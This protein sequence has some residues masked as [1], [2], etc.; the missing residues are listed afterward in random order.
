MKIYLDDVRQTPIGYIRCFNPAEV[1]LHLENDFDKIEEIS[2]D[3]DLGIIEDGKEKTGLDVLLYIEQMAYDGR[4]EKLPN[5]VIHS[6]NPAGVQR[7]KNALSSIKRR[8]EQQN[9]G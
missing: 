2:L 5:I 1:I 6:Q 9:E 3:H 8:I 4:I 7:M